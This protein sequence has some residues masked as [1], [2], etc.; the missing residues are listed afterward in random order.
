MR[1]MRRRIHTEGL[2]GCRTGWARWKTRGVYG[3]SSLVIFFKKRGGGIT[4]SFNL[5]KRIFLLL[6]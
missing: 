6:L 1:H 4:L 2:V 5:R 3:S